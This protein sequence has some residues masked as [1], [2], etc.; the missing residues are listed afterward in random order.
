MTVLNAVAY[1]D[2]ILLDYLRKRA[3]DSALRL[4]YAD[5]ASATGVTLRT[6]QRAIPRLENAGLISIE[7]EPGDRY[8]YRV[9]H[10]RSA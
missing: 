9:N 8:T 6:V 3:A 10:E 2:M 5:I 4:S 1:S 7:R